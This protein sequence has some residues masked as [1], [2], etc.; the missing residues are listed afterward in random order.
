MAETP[1]EAPSTARIEKFFS[2]IGT[3]CTIIGATALLLVLG[4]YV[5]AGLEIVHTLVTTGETEKVDARQASPV[6]DN[7]PN[8]IAYWK[9]FNKLWNQRFEP[10]Y[11]W[12]RRPY[13]GTFIKVDENGVRR[14]LGA[15]P[16]AD[17]TKIFMF[18]G[19]T[20]WGTGT[21]DKDTIPSLVQ[22]AL[23]SGYDVRNYG[24]SAWVSTQ[25]LNYLL[26]QLANGNVPDAV[27][28]YD[29]VNDGYAG[30]YSPGIPRDPHNLRR[31]NAADRNPLLDLFHETK[32]SRLLW[33]LQRTRN[34]MTA[35]GKDATAAW[36]EKME[37]RI[38]DNARGVVEMYKAHIKQVKALARE[39]GFKAFFFWQPN[40]FSMTRKPQNQYEKDMI[41]EASPVLIAS[42][43]K[44][45]EAAKTAFSN[46]EAENVFF[47][48][49]VFDQVAEPIYIDWHHV[50]P[51]GN[52]IV[53]DAML[54]HIRKSL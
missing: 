41:A 40:L 47:I 16:R 7:D 44:V 23:G 29:G 6:Y 50:G 53:V 26:Y 36:D 46:R 25:E 17:A 49:N 39:Y 27:V 32:Y 19:S 33:F 52:R 8:K 10:Y 45:Y 4:H 28:F 20:L 9:E 15:T 51:N 30:A 12:R 3:F 5:L 34:R 31:E 42:Q 1:G 14:T 54:A 24:D 18:G 48:G 35:G 11:H 13:D 43:K 2:R 22:A 37:S 21:A 38:D